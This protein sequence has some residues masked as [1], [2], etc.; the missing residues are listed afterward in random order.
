MHIVYHDKGG[1]H[2]SVVAAALHLNKLPFDTIP[3]RSQI[4]QLP[5]FNNTEHI[6]PG[7]LIFHGRDDNHHSIYTIG[8]K[9]APALVTNAI[10]SVFDL[11]EY[12]QK[13]ILCVDTSQAYDSLSSFGEICSLR[14]G[15]LRLGGS[16]GSFGILKAY[17]RIVAIVKKTR[18][19][20]AP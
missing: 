13:E 17:P 2:I 9:H 3:E 14:L 16:L 10:Q 11:A 7:R 12:D 15:L 19:K 5:L 6:R 18:L 8:R 4:L 20:T 1:V